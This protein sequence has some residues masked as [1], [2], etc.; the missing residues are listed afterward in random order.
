[1]ADPAPAPSPTQAVAPADLARTLL[2]GQD[3]ATLATLGRPNSSYKGDPYASLVLI[4]IDHDASP[5]LLISQLAEHTQNLLASP[6]MSL[7]I[8]GTA[9]LAEPLTGARV[10]L[11]GRAVRSDAARLRARFVAR[12]PGAAA[13]ADFGDFGFWRIEIARAHLVAGF[14][15]IHWVEANAF[16]FDVSSTGALGESEADIVAHMNADHADAV[17]LYATKLLGAAATAGR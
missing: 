12:H 17:Q 16:M 10:S 1:M 9:G 2:R 14:G 7:L 5:I 15:R 3:R 13:Y 11:Q 8:D 4:A 6:A